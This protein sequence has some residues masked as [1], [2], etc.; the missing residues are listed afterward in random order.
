ME[1]GLLIQQFEMGS[2][3]EVKLVK[4]RA[5]G[6]GN[7]IEVRKW[8]EIGVHKEIEMRATVKRME[9]GARVKRMKMGTWMR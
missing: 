9:T 6:F 5:M 1:Q 8:M 3:K 7:W 2:M 4:L